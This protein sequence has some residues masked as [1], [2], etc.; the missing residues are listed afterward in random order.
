[1]EMLPASNKTTSLCAMYHVV[2]HHL[3]SL[4]SLGEDINQRYILSLI[5]SKLPKVVTV[6]LEQ[7]EGTERRWTVEMLQ[8]NLK[9]SISVQEIGENQFL[10]NSEGDENPKAHKHKMK[11]FKQPF[12][13]MCS[14]MST[15]RYQKPTPKCF[16]CE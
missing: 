2:E 6:R 11:Q 16:Y 12:G 8:N 15:K 1:M 4:H 10:T 3:R 9:G 14:L 7:Q 13:T 5:R